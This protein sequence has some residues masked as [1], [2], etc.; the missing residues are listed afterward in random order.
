[1]CGPIAKKGHPAVGGYQ[2]NNLRILDSLQAQNIDIRALPYAQPQSRGIKKIAIYFCGFIA[3]AVR[4][5]TLQ[6][7]AIIHVT[8]LRRAF[9]APELVLILLAKIRRCRII[10]DIRDGLA[11]DSDLI[12]RSKNYRRVY[13]QA[14]KFADLVMV[15]GEAQISFVTNLCGKTPLHIPNQVD[16]KT[17]PIRSLRQEKGLNP[18]IAYAGAIKA[19]KG[20][21]I[22]LE[23]ARIMQSNGVSPKICL[24]GSGSEDFISNLKEEFKYL[25]MEWLGPL[26]AS[27]VLDLFSD[28]DFFVFPTQW[29]GEGQSNALTEAM[30]CGCVPVVSDHGF[31]AATVGNS[32]V[33][34]NAEATSVDYARELQRIWRTAEWETL[35]FR[36]KEQIK[37]KFSSLIIS[38]KLLDAYK[39]LGL[40]L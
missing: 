39:S 34:L 17:I 16:L 18:K 25:D 36:A 28:S 7:K 23:T 12:E 1:L 6:E 35:S 9:L 3:L 30:A 29:P 10:F 5:V 37:L 40:E 26:V 27:E 24:A 11:Q 38:K 2:S 14:L 32:G 15:E 13:A 4:V 21:W 20:I 31:N 8:A 33:V 22:I 19:E